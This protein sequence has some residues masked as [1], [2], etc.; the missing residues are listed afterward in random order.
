MATI[1]IREERGEDVEAIRLLN[2]RAFGGPAEAALVEALRRA[3]AITLSLVAVARSGAGAGAPLG[4]I[5]FSPVVLESA[6]GARAAVGLA[7]MAVQPERQRE[8]IGGRLI[9]AGLDRLRREGHGA[10][11]VVGHPEYYPRFG[12]VPASR[13][14]VRWEHAC[15]DEAFM[16]IELIPG[17]LRGGGVARYRPELSEV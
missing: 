12:F 2:E 16:A 8:G 3:G 11:V 17:A 6:A 5:L 10:V 7:P 13:L 9:R 1:E 15:P 4:H 14:G